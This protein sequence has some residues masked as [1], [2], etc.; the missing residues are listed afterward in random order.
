MTKGIA[1]RV[2]N[3]IFKELENQDLDRNELINEALRTYFEK[4]QLIESIE[5]DRIPDEVY[6]EVYNTLYNS[7]VAPL[8][9][10]LASQQRLTTVLSDEI[11]EYKEDKQFLKNQILR[12][13][14]NSS[15]KR[16]LFKKRK[17]NVT[18]QEIQD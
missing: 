17:K 3:E 18:F 8:L 13:Q 5:D 10:Q 2:S 6:I 1:I 9:K 12:L 7:E 15:S 16:S 14:E 11:K 4:N